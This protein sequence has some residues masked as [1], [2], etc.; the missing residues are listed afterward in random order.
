M[1]H[2]SIKTIDA[3]TP[4]EVAL[5]T[6]MISGQESLRR[7]YLSQAF[8]HAVA[9]GNPRVRVVLAYESSECFALLPLQRAAGILGRLGVWEPVGG[10][11]TDY[12]GVVCKPAG[13]VNI[14]E[15]L[16]A[17]KIGLVLFS[18]LDE[19]QNAFGLTG[20]KHRIGL[21]TKINGR[22]ETHWEQL[23]VSNKKLANDTERRERKLATDHGEIA[24]E[25]QSS[26]AAADLEELI[27]LKKAQYD[28]TGKARAPLFDEANAQLLRDLLHKQ[29]EFC[30]G[31]LSTLRVGGRLVAAHFGL[32]CGSVLHF[33]FP[34]YAKEFAA[35][36]PGRILFRHVI[37]AG[38]TMG[39]STLDRGEGDTPAKRDFSN[40]EHGFQSG[41]WRAA[42]VRGLVARLALA[43]Y[44]RL[45]AT[46]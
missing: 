8:C 41:I 20:T 35:Y 24:F 21:R 17:C 9:R 45:S 25:F 27:A 1:I 18:H 28:R 3:I 33:W 6:S 23:K 16:A 40:E 19:T 30:C 15:L 11:M 44:W 38:S 46:S 32:R 42:G 5:W 12:F 43:I 4:T 26:N 22:G 10:I 7:S 36:S 37:S 31:V 14:N 13:T 29:D 39:I 34:G 2:Y